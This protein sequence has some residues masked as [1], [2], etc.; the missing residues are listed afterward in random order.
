MSAPTKANEA[1]D[2]P[3]KKR[4]F[5]VM[6]GEGNADLEDKC[7]IDVATGNVHMK[8]IQEQK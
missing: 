3:L 5:V 4:I 8:T 2:P 6:Q 1:S 7:W